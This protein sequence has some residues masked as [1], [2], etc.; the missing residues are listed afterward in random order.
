[1]QLKTLIYS[2][3]YLSIVGSLLSCKSS[4]EVQKQNLPNTFRSEKPLTND[5]TTIAHLTYKEFYKDSEL[6]TLIDKALLKNNN[7]Q[8]AL[9]QIESASLDF[10]K[11]KWGNIPVVTG[12]LAQANVNRPSDNS[13]NGIMTK[14]FG[15]KSYI[16]DYNS[17]ATLSWE[18]DIWGKI[19]NTKRQALAAFLETQEVAKAIRVRLISQVVEG[20]YNL[21]LLDKQL[22]ITQ[23]NL[24]LSKQSLH[25][26]EKQFEVGS[27]SFIAVQQ[28]QIQV[29]ELEKS[30]PAIQNAINRQ[31]NA[32]QLLS[33]TFPKSIQRQNS[34]DSLIIP[35]D[36]NS[37]VPAQLLS[38]R[39]DV[40]AD[41]Y[42]LH[43]AIAFMKISRAQ[44]YPSLNITAQGGLNT[45]NSQNWFDIP[46]S[47]F[48][49]LATS[50]LQPI[51]Q[52]K[53]LSTNYK[54]SKV[55][56]E[57]AELQFKESILLAVNEVSNIL[58]DLEKLKEQR[59]YAEQIVKQ[60][61]TIID[62]AQI[63]F[64]SGEASYLEVLAAQSSKLNSELNLAAIKTQQLN[65]TTALYRALGGGSI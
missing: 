17:L 24:E 2:T 8:I 52:G 37:G 3:F 15:G 25:L 34:L 45:F 62:N 35:T 65:A 58:V 16:E 40:K 51:L 14:Q 64:T 56:I 39:P 13:F 46:G 22:K 5:T 53:Q 7:L 29:A 38:N 18:A 43:Q 48:G 20:Y 30:L 63:L 11:S 49:T 50:L 59:Q 1:M 32:I 27:V 36:L 6:I 9:K 10:K 21:L 23:S 57:Q 12:N 19:K 47:L 42:K 60:T 44:M 31:E 54:K 28:Q 33:G 41:E 26:F 4:Y 61:S 55:A